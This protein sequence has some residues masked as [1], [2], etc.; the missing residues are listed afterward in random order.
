MQISRQKRSK[1][2]SNLTKKELETKNL[3]RKIFEQNKKLNSNSKQ[4]KTDQEQTFFT[5]VG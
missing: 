1:T 4:I 2:T 5:S 3:R